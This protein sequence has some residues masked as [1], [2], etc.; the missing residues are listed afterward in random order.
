MAQMIWMIVL[1]CAIFA[2]DAQKPIVVMAERNTQIGIEQ[3]SLT[4]EPSGTVRWVQNSN[5]LSG[6]FPTRLGVFEI[7]NNA[8][9]KKE[10]TSLT[11][12]K[13]EK[14]DA[15][16]YLSPHRLKVTVGTVEIY[17]SS[18]VYQKIVDLLK[19]PET[20]SDWVVVDGEKIDAKTK[21]LQCAP[22]QTPQELLCKTRLGLIHAD[23]KYFFKK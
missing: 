1:E 3:I 13:S 22:D 21:S 7:K 2:A 18:K 19:K 14:L 15:N 16:I 20:R 8:E 5:F 10:I 9:L 6:A 17:P 23:R 4:L 11:S 12:I